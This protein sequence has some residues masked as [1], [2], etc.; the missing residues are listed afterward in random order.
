[1]AEASSS[2][3]AAEQEALKVST[4]RRLHPRVY[5]ER[6]LAEGVRPDGREFDES[7]EVT[8][9][10]GPYDTDVIQ[11][12]AYIYTFSRLNIHRQ[13]LCISTAWRNNRHMRGQSRNR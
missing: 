8:V 4:F 10:V 6:F 2:I 7:R 5:L 13:W 9:N 1:M 3:E 11:A 12:Y